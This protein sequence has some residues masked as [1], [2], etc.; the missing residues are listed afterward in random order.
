MRIDVDIQANKTAKSPVEGRYLHVVSAG[1]EFSIS[2]KGVGELF[3]NAG[4]YAEIP[5]GVKT[6]EYRDKS[7]SFN[8]VVL[9]NTD[10]I[11]KQAGE[12]VQVVNSIEVQRIVEPI[13]V[14]VT[15]E[16]TFPPGT[17]MGVMPP[18]SLQEIADVP[19]NSG[20]IGL[21]VA[22][23]PN[24]KKLM[25]V[26]TA[27]DNSANLNVCRLGGAGVVAGSGYKYFAGKGAIAIGEVDVTG[28]VHLFNEGQDTVTVSVTE[29]LK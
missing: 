10:V 4:G 6:L 18:A 11:K 26:I 7:G 1:G 28:P 13:A 27:P 25:F 14:E 21:I 23:N 15:A 20:S 12:Q 17:E 19:V 16:A 9:E 3:F 24:R 29:V 22:A 8:P 5:S 2:A